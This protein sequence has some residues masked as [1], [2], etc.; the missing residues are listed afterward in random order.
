MR[1]MPA[2]LRCVPSFLYRYKCAMSGMITV[3]QGLLA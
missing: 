2:A 1:A 3:R